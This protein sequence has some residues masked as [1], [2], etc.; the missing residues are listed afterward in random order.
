MIQFT[1]YL[2]VIIVPLLITGCNKEKP[3]IGPR[4]P[5]DGIT[6]NGLDITL[7][8][9]VV[10]NANSYPTLNNN[11]QILWKR[12]IGRKPILYNIA[13]DNNNIYTMDSNGSLH[14]I[15]KITGKRIYKQ[16]ITKTPSYNTF[17][18]S[19][20][21]NNGIIY[22]GTNTNE[23]I[24]FN[25]KDR[26]ILWNTKL[27]N[28]IKGTPVCLKDKVIV[29][30]INNYTYALNKN[31]GE[32]IW[33]YLS[34]KEPITLLSNSTPVLYNNSVIL[35]YSSGDVVS[36]DLNDGSIKWYELLIPN[37]MYNSGAGLLQPVI[38]P[39]II[40]DKILLSNVNSMMVLLDAELGTK[41]WEKK[42]G[43]ATNPVIVNNKWIFVIAN[44]NVLCVDLNNGNTQWKLD[45]KEMF[46]K[47][48]NYKNSF[49]YGPLLINNQLWIFSTNAD[50]LKL[51]LSSG[52]VIEKQYIHHV[53]YTDTPVIDH[54][55]LFAQ[56]R[57]NIYALQ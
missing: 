39:I 30:T 40:E 10:I 33:N 7:S 51:D 1:K 4:E 50:I 32:I 42:I 17:Y 13:I 5:I 25:T 15:N 26:K 16:F 12:S 24:A 23:V 18:S 49:W 19:I 3:L 38:S 6:Y 34:E 57:G 31:N 8:K 27:D 47:D 35:T 44:N 9:N 41:I 46:K 11:L 2:C 48:K 56:V 21:I 52:K 45:L 36:L 22:I 29:N 53:L 54:N 55:K 37:Y 28:T 14:C 43:T 20:S